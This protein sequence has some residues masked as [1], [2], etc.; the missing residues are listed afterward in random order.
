[1]LAAVKL[2]KDTL[3]LADRWKIFNTETREKPWTVPLTARDQFLI[4]CA[5]VPTL[6]ALGAGAVAEKTAEAPDMASKI[7][8]GLVVAICAVGAAG[9]ETLGIISTR[10]IYRRA[11]ADLGY[12]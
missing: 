9:F 10:K 5:T 3:T 11:K 2:M 6:L 1:M 8:G 4:G 7:A 12:N